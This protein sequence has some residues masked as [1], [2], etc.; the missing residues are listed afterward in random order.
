MIDPATMQVVDHFKVG[1]TAPS[2][3]I[4]SWDLKTL[5]VASSAKGHRFPA[6]SFRSI[7]KPAKPGAI[8]PVHDAYNMYFMPDGSAAIVV[9]EALKRLEFRDPQ[10]MELQ[11]R[12]RVPQCAGINHADFAI[13]GSYAIF[14]C[15]FRGGGLVKIDLAERKILGYLKLWAHA[16]HAAGHPH[17]PGWQGVLRR[18]HDVRRRASSSTATAFTEV[19]FI[20]T[21]VGA[22]GLYPSRDGKKLYVSNRGT[23]MSEPAHGHGSVAVIDF[24]TRTV[25]STWPIPGGGSPDMGNVSADG[26]TLWLSGRFDNVVYAIDTTS[27]EVT[28][29]PVGRSRTGS[30]CGRSPA[31]I[32]SAIPATCGSADFPKACVLEIVAGVTCAGRARKPSF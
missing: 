16:G 30:P 6:A 7:P 32:R 18:R 1:G 26:S 5:W 20:A 24:A 31:A 12:C 11:A 9:A 22:H 8:I 29:I 23:H 2:T 3:S 21:G 10:T 14:T 13:D 25:E 19:G 28:S 17:R 4:P 15:E 27:G